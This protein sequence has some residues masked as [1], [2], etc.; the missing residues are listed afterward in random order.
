VLELAVCRRLST[1]GGVSA[2]SKWSRL[3]G[4]SAWIRVICSIVIECFFRG[5]IFFFGEGGI[6]GLKGTKT[7]IFGSILLM[8]TFDITTLLF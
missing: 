2:F 4:F 8:S 6:L 1:A 5:L 3:Y 7:L